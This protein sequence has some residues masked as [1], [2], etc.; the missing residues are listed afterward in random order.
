MYAICT[1]TVA[2]HDAM[3]RLTA[4]PDR[5]NTG[6]GE[7]IHSTKSSTGRS[8]VAF[9]RSQDR[10]RRPGRIQRHRYKLLPRLARKPDRFHFG[11]PLP[12]GVMRRCDDKAA[13]R[14]ALNFR[15]APHGSE[16]LGRNSGFDTGGGLC[17]RCFMTRR[18]TARPAARVAP[19]ALL[20]P[21]QPDDGI[22]SP[23][24]AWSRLFRPHGA[25]SA[26][27]KPISDDL[28]QKVVR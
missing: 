1:L 25:Q 3:R 28:L 8:A 16:R 21:F 2:K 24:Q 10:I 22:W 15:G 5:G 13:D 19:A 26:Q 11:D 17:S 18:E 12:G 6:R 20:C 14:A 7:P 27:N 23:D 9:E 4:K